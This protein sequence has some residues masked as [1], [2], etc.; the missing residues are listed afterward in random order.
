[1]AAVVECA[2]RGYVAGGTSSG[3]ARRSGAIS[4]LA[5]AAVADAAGLDLPVGGGRTR[6]HRFRDVDEDGHAVHRQLVAGVGLEDH[7]AYDSTGA[8]RAG[9]ELIL[10]P[11]RR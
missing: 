5:A 10:A 7:S 2:E 4:A 11:D 1:M 9:R 6:F 3:G 8:Q